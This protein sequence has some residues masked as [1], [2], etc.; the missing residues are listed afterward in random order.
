MSALN[1]SS[2]A[3][4]ESSMSS[5]LLSSSLGPRAVPLVIPGSPVPLPAPLP[6]PLSV[7]S[8]ENA[9]DDKKSMDLSTRPIA[10]ITNIPSEKNCCCCSK[11]AAKI[12][13]VTLG[14]IGFASGL[15][16]GLTVN[17]Y[18]FCI[19][20]SFLLVFPGICPRTVPALE[21]EERKKMEVLFEN[22]MSRWSWETYGYRVLIRCYDDQRK[23]VNLERLKNDTQTTHKKLKVLH[24]KLSKYS[25]ELS[26]CEFWFELPLLPDWAKA[27]IH[28]QS[29]AGIEGTSS[30]AAVVVETPSSEPK[31]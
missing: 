25:A 2:S 29:N 14:I 27:Q 30:E 20:A 7:L 6:V 17:F 24:E 16:L 10:D 9:G 5:S 3:Y 12:A 19:C 26:K 22:T 23:N 28:E 21:L 1:A 8:E 31:A 15:T 18:C 13:L 11:T 4:S